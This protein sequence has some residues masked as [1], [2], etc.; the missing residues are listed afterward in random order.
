MVCHSTEELEFHFELEGGADEGAFPWVGRVWQPTTSD[1]SQVVSGVDVVAG[2]VVLE[3]QGQKVSGYTKGDVLAWMKHC[4]KNRN[5]VVISTASEGKTVYISL[6]K[7][8]PKLIL[9]L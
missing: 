3:I 4:M 2:D 7:A 6:Y 1:S 9:D 8:G 5:P